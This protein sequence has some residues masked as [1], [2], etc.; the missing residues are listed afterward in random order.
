MFPGLQDS[1]LNP[2]LHVTR[3]WSGRGA[4]PTLMTRYQDHF[5][6]ARTQQKKDDDIYPVLILAVVVLFFAT[7]Q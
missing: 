3:Q 2:R 1:S 6:T 7:K 4:T 5:E